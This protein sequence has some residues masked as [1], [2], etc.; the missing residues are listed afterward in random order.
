MTRRPL[1]PIVASG[2]ACLLATAW[3]VSAAADSIE[4]APREEH[5]LADRNKDGVIDRGEF[6]VRMVEV[7]YHA[8]TDRDGLLVLPELERIDEAMVYRPA[9]RDGDGKLTLSEYVD[10]RFEGFDAA[11]TNDDGVLSVSEV[12]EAWEAP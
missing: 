1:R 2:L 5:A 8:D 7:F 6:H 11:D 4:Y 10:H 12:V 9:D 3:V